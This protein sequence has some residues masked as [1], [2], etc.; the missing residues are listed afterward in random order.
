M[1]L[2]D[3][4]IEAIEEVVTSHAQRKPMIIIV[5]CGHY[6]PHMRFGGK[7]HLAHILLQQDWPDLEVKYVN[8]QDRERQR[9]NDWKQLAFD[10]VTRMRGFEERCVMMELAP[11]CEDLVKPVR[12]LYGPNNHSKHS[13]QGRANRWR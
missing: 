7:S 6:D 12:K 4:Q 2:H 8:T 9:L 11:G 13:R 3:Y 10:E 1:E 5:G